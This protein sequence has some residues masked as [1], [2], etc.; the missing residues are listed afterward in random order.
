MPSTKSQGC[1]TF[2]LPHVLPI[3]RI[4]D[5]FLRKGLSM[6]LPRRLRATATMLATCGLVLANA[7]PA[8]AVWTGVA[9]GAATGLS[10]AGQIFSLGLATPLAVA[11]YVS[12]GVGF[13]GVCGGLDDFQPSFLLG[14]SAGANPTCSAPSVQGASYQPYTV[15]AGQYGPLYTALNAI[16]ADLNT[17]DTD[18]NNGAPASQIESDMHTIGGA[19]DSMA[20][21]YDGLAA[22]VTVT[23]AQLNA[24]LADIASSGLPSDELTFLQDAGWS[25][26]AISEF[27]AY[28]GHMTINL[29]DPSVTI[30]E[31]IH[32]IG[33]E[34]DQAEIPEPGSLLILATAACACLAVRRK[35]FQG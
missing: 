3:Q 9:S 14:P 15:P 30:S 6:H 8:Q 29:A 7:K 2:R 1:S 16:I 20:T 35:H 18:I 21:I 23:Q 12:Q 25:T 17:M 33:Q 24:A 22:P 31:D 28:V 19:I 32:A 10:A 34:F 13:A 27:Q 5:R 4:F 26:T 11:G